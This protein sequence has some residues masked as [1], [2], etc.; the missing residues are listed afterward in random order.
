MNH[1]RDQPLSVQLHLLIDTEDAGWGS[2]WS[3]S[4]LA[5][6]GKAPLNQKLQL[7]GPQTQTEMALIVAHSISRPQGFALSMSHYDTSTQ[8][9]SPCITLEDV[10]RKVAASTIVLV[11][12]RLQEHVPTVQQLARKYDKSIVFFNAGDIPWRQCYSVVFNAIASHSLIPMELFDAFSVRT[13][14]T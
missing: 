8:E 14:S 12:C 3:A 4:F 1:R 11:C 10:I 9:N 5:R 6:G 7:E 2:L 13:H